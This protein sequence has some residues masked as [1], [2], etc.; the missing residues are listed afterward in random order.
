MLVDPDQGQLDKM[1]R[2]D[3]DEPIVMLNLLRFREQAVAG[4]GV[5]GKTGSEA[6]AVYA[7]G[8]AALQTRFGGE[9][10]YT[11]RGGTGLIVTEGE[12]WHIVAL[13][14]YPSR[15]QFL[16]MLSD[17]EYQAIAPIRAAALADSRLVET[18]S[19]P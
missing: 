7:A 12:K 11:G 2:R 14:R 16:D 15:K 1:A 3:P 8:Y 6:F 13:V 5:D 4:H 18:T 10:I 19:L 9:P 17:P